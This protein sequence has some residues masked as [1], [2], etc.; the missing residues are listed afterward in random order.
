MQMWLID[1]HFLMFP[2]MY[3]DKLSH[4]LLQVRRESKHFNVQTAC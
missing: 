4:A 3:I 2:T 1:N